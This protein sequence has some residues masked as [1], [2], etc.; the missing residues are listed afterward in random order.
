MASARE[1]ADILERAAAKLKAESREP[2]SRARPLSAAENAEAG[3]DL[4]KA[5]SAP[6][7]LKSGRATSRGFR[8][9]KALAYQ[10]GYIDA[11]D[12][13]V[14]IDGIKLFT[15]ALQD[16][17]SNPSNR[18]NNSFMI[19]LAAELLPDDTT[20]HDGFR[21][22][23]S[24]WTAGTAGFDRGE[25]EWLRDKYKDNP[26]HPVFKTAQSYLLDTLGGTLVAPPEQGEL[27]ELMRPRECLMNAGA[28]RVPLP[29][30][31]RI[32]FP[33]QTA[34]T[35]MY[36]VGENTSITESNVATGQI[37]LQAKKGAVFSTLPNE[38]LKY[39]SVAADA[40][41]RN[42][43]AKT[44][45]LGVDYAGLYGTGGAA[46]PKGLTLYTGT[47]E[48]INYAGTTPTP[49]GVAADGN[50]LKPEDGYFMTGLIEDRN[51]EQKGWIMR[52]TLANNIV[53]FR[54]DAV[55]PSDKAGQFV[56]GMMRA[57]SDKLPGDIWCGW[58]VTKSA[59]VKN[60][61]TKGASGATLT[62]LFGGQWE[63][64]MV[65]MYGAVEF[66]T[67]NQAGTAFQQDQ[68]VVRTM[69]FCDIAPRYPGAFVWY[70]ELKLR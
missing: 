42:D 2:A 58:K 13:A 21:T 47:N 45:A 52:P 37:S 53:G 34:P 63:H 17:G 66:A 1:Q 68:T 33:T 54:A 41:I 65:G 18:A 60:N 20:A 23:K 36:W 50:T 6:G 39:A 15:K 43:S 31:G 9:S 44:L 49:S 5:L 70:K 40:L 69:I 22:F 26:N 19:P 59:V 32:S 55:A 35:S 51:F 57:I 7:V 38:L 12:A 48:V 30:Q 10:Q 64:L 27:I 24:M 14:E 4:N 16:T 11:E 67:S 61:N 56:Q 29:P 25:V 8:L 46:Q 3:R 28:T 62:D